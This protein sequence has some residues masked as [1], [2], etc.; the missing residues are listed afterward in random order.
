MATSV[1]TSNIAQ[2][3]IF[4]PSRS[5]G[6]E[7]WSRLVKNKAAV[8]GMIIIALFS[9]ISIFAPVFSPH[10]PVHIFKGSGFLPPPWYESNL[11]D[12]DP[13]FFLG[14]DS[15]GRDVLSRLI[16]GSRV[17][18]VVGLVPTVIILLVGTV[19]GMLAGYIGGHLDNLLMRITDVVY[20]FPDL[21]FF[22]IVTVA[23]R[24]QPIGQFMNGLFLLFTALA[25]IGWTSVARL[26]RGQVLSLKQKE[27]VEAARC[28]GVKDARIMFRHILPNSF[29]PLIVSAAITVP[30]LIIAEAILGYFG[31]GLRPANQLEGNYFI[32]SWG[33]LMLDGQPAINSQPFILLAPAISIAIVVLAFTFVGDGLRDAL[34][35]RMRGTQ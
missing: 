9:M 14:T 30:N 34:D 4:R 8:V 18:M 2:L 3:D 1:Q 24:D 20:A 19:V 21:L 5:P 35:P 12:G 16:Y 31:L 27:F 25:I 11:K 33:S 29:G 26:V 32:T 7:A 6:A 23:L 22:I 28:I 17:S 15:I 10:D 13:R